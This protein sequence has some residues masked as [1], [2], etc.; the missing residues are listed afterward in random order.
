MN[1]VFGN[2]STRGYA[3]VNG[4]RMYYE[5]S[6]A[7]NPLVYIPPALGCVGMKS[8]PQLAETHSI[9][10]MDLQG[11]GRT[12]DISERP[13]SL[14]QN[15]SDVI[16][17][18][19]HLGIAGADFLGESYGGVVAAMIAI[20]R[21]DLVRR[22]AAYA[23]T[24][25]PPDTA[26]NMEM[27]HTTAPLAADSRAFLFQRESYQRVAP[28]P[29]YWPRFWN[30]A[31]AIRWTGFSK[32]E[33]AAISA[34]FLI[35]Q[36]DRDFVRLEHAVETLKLIPNAELAVIPNAGHFA[37]FSEPERVIP[38]VVDF[39]QRPEKSLP[40]ATAEIGYQPGQT[41]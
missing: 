1:Q 23:A 33:L 4:L 27:L 18:L 31:S 12:A 40:V 28:D 5:I 35:V 30:K 39:L 34:P 10:T 32:A 21:P 7:G 22:V 20:R 19:Q 3:P 14:E 24:F 13:M 15:A 37:L 29:D 26:L 6:G 17:L 38:V 2:G 25:G 16:G 41:R 36:G 11:H 9:I 8:F